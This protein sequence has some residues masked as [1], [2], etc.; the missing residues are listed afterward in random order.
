MKERLR[1]AQVAQDGYKSLLG[2]NNISGNVDWKNRAAHLIK[3]ARL[4]SQRLRVLYRYALED[5]RAIGEN[6]QRLYS[7]DA[8]R[9]C[10]YYTDRER[11][12]CPG[13]RPHPDHNGHVPD[14]VYEESAP[15]LHREGSCPI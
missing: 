2:W 4:P 7:L 15:A 1:Y 12:A 10:P 14:S 5:L 11:A 6:E 3:T 13:P 9:E 8:W